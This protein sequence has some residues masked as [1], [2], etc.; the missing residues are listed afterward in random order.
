LAGMSWKNPPP[1]VVIGGTEDYLRD[2]EVRNAILQSARSKKAIVRAEGDADVID[3]Y[4]VASTFGEAT[5]IVAPAEKISPKTVSSVREDPAPG[6]CLLIQVEGPLDPSKFPYLGEIHAA[7]QVE[8]VRPTTKKGLHQ[9]AERFARAEADRLLGAK[10]TLDPKL[11]GAL[12]GAV[13]TD[14]GVV[15]FEIQK[16]AALARAKG[17]TQ[18][19]AGAVRELIRGSNELDLSGLREALKAK[20]PSR[21]ATEMDRLRR[22][23]AGDPP[24]MLLLRAKG[25]PADLAMRW[26]TCALMMERGSSEMEISLRLGEPEWAVSKDLIPAAKKWGIPSLRVLVSQLAQVDRGVLKG[27]PNPW[28]A[29]ESSLLL[30]ALR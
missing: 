26:L 25:G 20:S 1:I 18:I 22:K 28:V 11:A 3:A 19:D 16:M 30:A 6:S 17:S 15:H 5:L 8:H 9:L 10:G 21:I 23:S 13:G 24:L 29:L 4:G 27:S 12:V 2:R 7:Y 14:L